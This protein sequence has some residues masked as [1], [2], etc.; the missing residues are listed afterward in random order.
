MSGEIMQWDLEA[1]NHDTFMQDEF[2]RLR[3]TYQVG[4]VI[5]T[6]TFKGGTTLWLSKNF[7]NVWSC[8]INAVYYLEAIDKFKDCDNVICSLD[9]SPEFLKKISETSKYTKTIVFLDAHWYKNPVSKELEVLKNFHTKPILVIHDFQNPHHPE[10]GY[11]SYIDQTYSFAAIKSYIDDIYG[12]DG[13][14]FY[15]NEQATGAKR[16]CIFIIPRWR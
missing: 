5:E 14:T 4:T 2:I 12:K 8:E 9:N 13:Y 3:D 11:D 10:F 1:F 15:Y 6:G 7:D 16:G